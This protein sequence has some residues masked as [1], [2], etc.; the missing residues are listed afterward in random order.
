MSRDLTENHTLKGVVVSWAS[1]TRALSQTPS[2]RMGCA[3]YF[4]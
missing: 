2:F 3:S 4:W 1:K